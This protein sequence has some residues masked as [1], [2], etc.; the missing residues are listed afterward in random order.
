[1]K[2]YLKNLCIKDGIPFSI[3][4]TLSI[5]YSLQQYSTS[6]ALIDITEKKR[7]ALDDGNIACGVFVDW[8]KAFDTVDHQ[9]LLAKLNHYRLCGAS[10]AWCKSYPNRNRYI[11]IYL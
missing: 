9:I 11:G 3:T 10:N 8:Q 7:K 2:K 5:T 4:I 1:M 6:H